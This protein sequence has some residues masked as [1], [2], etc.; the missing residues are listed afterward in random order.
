[1]EEAPKKKGRFLGDLYIYVFIVLLLIF[2]GL[3]TLYYKKILNRSI[4]GISQA[5]AQAI[6]T[7]STFRVEKKKI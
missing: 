4:P 1:M 3:V 2:L 7:T 6:K 5:H